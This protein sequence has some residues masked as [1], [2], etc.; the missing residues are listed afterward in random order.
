M[1]T[2]IFFWSIVRLR[3][4]TTILNLDNILTTKFYEDKEDKLTRSY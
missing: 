4:R 2:N 1:E 3:I